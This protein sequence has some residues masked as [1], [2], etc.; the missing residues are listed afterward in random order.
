[1][2]L[3]LF[4]EIIFLRGGRSQNLKIF[5]KGKS[6]I[7]SAFL[8]ILLLLKNKKTSYID[9]DY[10]KPYRHPFFFQPSRSEINHF[11]C[12]TSTAVICSLKKKTKMTKQKTEKEVEIDL[13]EN[14]GNG[15]VLLFPP[16]EEGLGLFSVLPTCCH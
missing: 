10:G 12:F 5:Q 1:M 3:S 16:G 7:S 8:V 15:D 11:N 14:L 4:S 9:N 13:R 2:K 6:C